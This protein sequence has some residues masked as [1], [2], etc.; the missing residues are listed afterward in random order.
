MATLVCFLKDLNK[1]CCIKVVN[2]LHIVAQSCKN[3]EPLLVNIWVQKKLQQ[4]SLCRDESRFT[5]DPKFWSNVWS[6]TS[7]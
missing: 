3:V 4:Q 7:G 1:P 5:L 6:P 2:V